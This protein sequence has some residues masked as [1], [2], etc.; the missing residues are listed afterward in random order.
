MKKIFLGLLVVLVVSGVA[1]SLTKDELKKA[2]K[3]LSPADL[4]EI[5]EN[6]SIKMLKSAE[7][8][9]FVEGSTMGG[10]GGFYVFRPVD[11]NKNKPAVL[12]D[13]KTLTGGAGGFLC[14]LDKN[15]ALGFLFGGMGGSSSNKISSDYYEYS[16]G[17]FFILPYLKYKPIIQPSFI[18]DLNLGI[19]WMTGGYS[20]SKTDE[21]LHGQDVERSGTVWP[22]MLEVEGRYRI[23]P[24][25]H[26]GL[27]LGYL[28]ANITDLKRAGVVDATA[29][30]LDFSGFY[31]ALC[32]GG[33]F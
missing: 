26:T 23:N 10:A 2:I 7:Q 15:W 22:I 31:L 11:V 28:L 1:F 3:D 16:V 4:K 32:M 27:K 12:S 6:L 24:V 9:G 8:T 21:N 33:N 18:V 17:A 13:L 5:S 14:N 30:S 19:G 25:W 29:K 20:Y